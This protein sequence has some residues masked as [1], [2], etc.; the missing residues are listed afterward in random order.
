M[1]FLRRIAHLRYNGRRDNECGVDPRDFKR[2]LDLHAD[3]TVSDEQIKRVLLP[4]WSK[5]KNGRVTTH[6]LQ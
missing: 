5:I 2:L 1:F 4:A 3:E 6:G